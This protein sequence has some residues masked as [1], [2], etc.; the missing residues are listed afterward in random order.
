MLIGLA[1][2]ALLLPILSQADSFASAVVLNAVFTVAIATMVTPS[3]A[4]MAEATAGAGVPSFGVAYGVYN[5]AWALGLLIGPAIGGAAY[6]EVG[7]AVLTVA[8]AAALLP[9]TLLLARVEPA[10]RGVE[11]S[12]GGLT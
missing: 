11:S 1:G 8:W 6:E 2:I 12:S 7:F 9:L 5:C 3:L 10:D 4:Y